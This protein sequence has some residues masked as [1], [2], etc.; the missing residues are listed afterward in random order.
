M[1]RMTLLVVNFGGPRSLQEIPIFL[2]AL[3]TDKDVI[4]TSLP[5]C[6]QDFLFKRIAKTRAGQILSD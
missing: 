3:L 5:E 2:E 4:R 6:I 1:S